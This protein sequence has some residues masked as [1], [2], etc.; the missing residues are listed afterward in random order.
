M[1]LKVS[2]RSKYCF[3]QLVKLYL[4]VV[5]IQN[6]TFGGTQGFTRKPSTPW[7][8]DSGTFAGIVHQE[9]NLTYVL[10]DGASHLVPQKKPA[11]AFF[12][13]REFVLGS[14]PAGLV[15]S[16]SSSAIGE[17]ST[18]AGDFLPGNTAIF[19]GSISTTT[20]MT[21]PAATVS[22]WNNFV[23]SVA[24]ADMAAASKVSGAG[25]LK[26]LPCSRCFLVPLVALLVSLVAL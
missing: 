23:S 9:R 6:T 2:N 10:F 26:S 18:L 11:A 4:P 8:D 7:S 5:T 13:L 19:G 21:Y 16:G 14:N 17:E 15:E 24:V 1:E 25:S 20:T 22:A 12:F 3:S